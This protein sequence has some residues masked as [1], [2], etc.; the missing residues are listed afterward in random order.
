MS[1]PPTRSSR[2]LCA[3]DACRRPGLSTDPHGTQGA[4]EAVLVDL[5]NTATL[6]DCSIGKR[7]AEQSHARPGLV[8]YA[9]HRV[10]VQCYALA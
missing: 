10:A 4:C 1:Q 3:T 9:N 2:H 6:L 7:V 5:E 8:A